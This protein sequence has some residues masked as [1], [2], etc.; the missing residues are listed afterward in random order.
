MLGF[1]PA[2]TVAFVPALAAVFAAALTAAV[3]A[4]FT[5][6]E[7]DAG[8]DGAAAHDGGLAE[9]AEP[10]HE[11]QRRGDD[12]GVGTEPR[13]AASCANRTPMSTTQTTTVS[14]VYRYHRCPLRTNTRTVSPRARPPATARTA[15]APRT[16]P[17]RTACGR[18]PPVNACDTA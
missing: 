14:A 11:R 16:A 6:C 15:P 4:A 13:A 12:G 2:L 3:A 1:G 18:V 17:S 7:R 8:G 10:E 9:E 5:G